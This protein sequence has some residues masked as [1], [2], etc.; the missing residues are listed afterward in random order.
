MINCVS[1][2][3]AEPLAIDKK[4]KNSMSLFLLASSAIL[5]AIET[6][7]LRNCETKPNFS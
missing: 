4:Y 3:K 6:L 1:I 2:S 5:D 7:A